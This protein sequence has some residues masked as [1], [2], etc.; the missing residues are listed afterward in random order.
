[1]IWALAAK[2]YSVIYTTN[3]IESLNSVIRKSVKTKR[4]PILRIQ[5]WDIQVAIY[6]EEYGT[7]VNHQP[8]CVHAAFTLRYDA[9][10]EV[11]TP[12]AILVDTG[13]K[14]MPLAI[15]PIM[16]SEEVMKHQFEAKNK[17]REAYGGC[18][19]WDIAVNGDNFPT[20]KE[21]A[22]LGKSNRPVLVSLFYGLFYGDL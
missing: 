19:V 12:S 15:F 3:A 16:T 8:S 20:L 6:A 11:V 18:W 4:V 22:R 17:W 21:A 1:V 14:P 7:V 9:A 10:S 13:K 2:R 5:K